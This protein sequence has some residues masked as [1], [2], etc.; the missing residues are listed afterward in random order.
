[1]ARPSRFSIG[2]CAGSGASRLFVLAL[3]RPEVHERFPGLFANR[4]ATEIRLPPLPQRACAKFVR[5]VIG[6]QITGRQTWIGSSIGRRATASIW[7]S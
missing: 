7:R 5:E 6:D 4:D 2:P 3:A 1:M